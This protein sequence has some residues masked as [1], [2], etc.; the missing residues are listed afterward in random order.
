[1]EDCGKKCIHSR[2]RRVGRIAQAA[3][4]FH[5]AAQAV[6]GEVAALD[7]ADDAA[8]LDCTLALPGQERTRC[9]LAYGRV[10]NA[11]LGRSDLQGVG[12]GRVPIQG[13]FR[14]CC[15]CFT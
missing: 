7:E 6:A 5:V 4:D 2:R 15:N 10:A 14:S 11:C 12:V 9:K 13:S 3:V 1:M 8:T